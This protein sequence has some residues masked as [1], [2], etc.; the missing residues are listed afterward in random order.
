MVRQ[1]LWPSLSLLKTLTG[2]RLRKIQV[3]YI[4]TPFS[5]V[6][7]WVMCLLTVTSKLKSVLEPA[8][9]LCH[10]LLGYDS[11]PLMLGLNYRPDW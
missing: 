5:T 4:E 9:P 10:W 1:R 3:C 11:G 6:N 2:Y 7:R 8:L